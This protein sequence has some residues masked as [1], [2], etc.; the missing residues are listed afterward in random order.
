VNNEM[1]NEMIVRKFDELFYFESESRDE[2][3]GLH[4]SAIIFGEKEFCYREQ[5]LSLYYKR[6][7]DSIVP[8]VKRIFLNGWYVHEKWQ[9]L[10]ELG[11][12]AEHIERT[13]E[14][15]HWKI[16]LT[17]DAIIRLYNKRF[18]VEIK[19]MSTKQFVTLRKTPPAGAVRQCQLYMHLTGIP[20][21]IILIEDK[22]NQQF[23][24]FTIE[25]DPGIAWEFINRLYKI[26]RYAD[27][28]ESEKKAPKR[29]PKCIT[30]G[31]GR[32]K[33]CPMREACFGIK[34]EKLKQ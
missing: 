18:V 14:S 34:R 33:G 5:V 25:Y 31:V 17:P 27:I 24:V 3:I 15:K 21:G 1:L 7:K 20:N 19:S 22:N 16:F 11:R 30:R 13:R 12:I 2:R 28:F 4:A 29:N 32:A 9:N 10:F 6:S 8:F 23:R 26:K